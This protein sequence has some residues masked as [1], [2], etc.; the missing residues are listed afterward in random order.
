ME[1]NVTLYE[2]RTT[3]K[4]LAPGQAAHVPYEIYQGLSPPG[5]PDEGARARAFEFA[6]ANG[7]EIANR[8]AQRGSDA[9]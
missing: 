4:D 6:K 1:A 3:L 5:E 7:C 8:T 9:I 2:F